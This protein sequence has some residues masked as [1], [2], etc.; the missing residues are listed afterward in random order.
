MVTPGRTDPAMHMG[1]K[2]TA[3]CPEA[4]A[5]RWLALAHRRPEARTFNISSLSGT[6]GLVPRGRTD[7]AFTSMGGRCTFRRL[8]E[9][10][11]RRLACARRRLSAASFSLGSGRAVMACSGAHMRTLLRVLRRASTSRR[12]LRVSGSS[13]GS[14]STCR[15]LPHRLSCAARRYTRRRTWRR[16]QS[17]ATCTAR[18]RRTHKRQVRAATS[19]HQHSPIRR[20][21]RPRRQC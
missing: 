14:A 16:I 13:R 15:A 18:H 20:C 8:E 2:W 4:W 6:M 7:P 12:K 5:T 11:S 10:G 3:R 21:K 19:S 17:W 1:G 9:H